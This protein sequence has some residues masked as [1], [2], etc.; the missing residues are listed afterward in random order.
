M[1][2]RE[3]VRLVT[4]ASD[5]DV[6]ALQRLMIEYHEPL[7][8]AVGRAL[9]GAAAR[10]VDPDDVLQD[11]YV[12]AFQAVD[13]CTFD[14]PAAFYKWLETVAL[15][16]LKDQLRALGRQKRDI[17][18]EAREPE[19]GRTTY[20]ELAARLVAADSTPSHR[21]ARGEA[22]AAVVS[23]LARLTGDQRDVVRL[24]F[25]EGQSVA[26]VAAFL[27]KS[28]PAIHMLCHRGLKA[29]RTLMVSMSGFLTRR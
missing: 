11:A 24:R 7:R 9:D 18:R 28:E 17:A 23:S 15:N 29:L 3:R 12:A 21:V 22:V 5:G 26:E 4:L 27:G 8:V 2:E 10:R 25:L 19:N 6:D 1:V 16:Q 13:R 20:P 14:G